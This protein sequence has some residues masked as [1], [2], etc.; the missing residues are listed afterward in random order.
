MT[1]NRW[2]SATFH[3]AGWNPR[4]IEGI[5]HFVFYALEYHTGKK[6]I[7]GRPVRLGLYVGSLLR[8]QLGE[9]ML[10]AIHRVGVDIRRRQG[11]LPGQT[12]AMR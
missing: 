11:G 10:A 8:N 4:H 9:E 2:S 7:Y 5:D 1:A 3:N 6:F 12:S